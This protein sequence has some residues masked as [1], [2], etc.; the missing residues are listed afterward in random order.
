MTPWRVT[1]NPLAS[2]AINR[3]DKMLALNCANN[4]E[5]G[6]VTGAVLSIMFKY[7][8]RKLR[9]LRRKRQQGNS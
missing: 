4:E 6:L 1:I 3:H 8:T 9:S 2:P 5:A 7:R